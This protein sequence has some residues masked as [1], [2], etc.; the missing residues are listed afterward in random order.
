MDASL[1]EQG[2]EAL[3]LPDYH[4]VVTES[5]E[6]HIHHE[7]MGHGDYSGGNS[8]GHDGMIAATD[9]HDYHQH[10]QHDMVD[11]SA[12][13]PAPMLID[14]SIDDSQHVHSA[15]LKPP[16]DLSVGAAQGGIGDGGVLGGLQPIEQTSPQQQQQA[17]S[18]PTKRHVPSRPSGAR[19][20]PTRKMKY[21]EY[22]EDNLKLAVAAILE[23]GMSLRK[24][25]TAYGVPKTTL[26]ERVADRRPPPAAAKPKPAVA[27]LGFGNSGG[28]S[29]VPPAKASAP[30]IITRRREDSSAATGTGDQDSTLAGA[31]VDH[32]DDDIGVHPVLPGQLAVGTVASM[33]FP[34]PHIPTPSTRY[35]WTEQEMLQAVEAVQSGLTTVAD[36]A[37]RFGV[38]PSNLNSRAR[39]REPKHLKGEMSRLTLRQESLIAEWARCQAALGLPATKDEV[40]EFAERILQRQ[41]DLA[42]GGGRA[43]NK[44]GKA[45]AAQGNGDEEGEGV[46]RLGKQWIMHWHRRW[47]HVEILDWKDAETSRLKRKRKWAD[48]GTDEVSGAAQ[49]DETEP[50]VQSGNYVGMN[51]DGP[52]VSMMSIMADD[53]EDL[54]QRQHEEQL[55]AS[56]NQAVHEDIG[57]ELQHEEQQQ[58]QQQHESVPQHDMQDPDPDMLS[59]QDELQQQLEQEVADQPLMGLYKD[60]AGSAAEVE[61]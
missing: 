15:M 55:H 16:Q 47:P 35:T 43:K 21:R 38:P 29:L 4:D 40:W 39:G 5:N 32:T 18:P 28:A 59:V 22:T 13:P 27:G 49:Q 12:A 56:D 6:Q 33:P 48:D 37:K 19:G 52:D 23:K 57:L 60:L 34:Q 61:S 2:H 44:R 20:G 9:G 10:H 17:Q 1:L 36:A 3:E 7:Q 45:K 58:H 26:A 46:K 8:G 42:T 53:H 31:N 51:Q 14:P 54:S 30:V 50:D 24:A 41:Q 11:M 25:S